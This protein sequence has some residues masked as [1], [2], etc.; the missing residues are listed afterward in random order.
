ML[1][2]SCRW[3]YYCLLALTL[4]EPTCCALLFTADAGR[5]TSL[6]L[7]NPLRRTM[8]T[9]QNV[10]H[11]TPNTPWQMVSDI[12]PRRAAKKQRAPT[13]HDLEGA[14][15]AE[16]EAA[17]QDE[18][19]PEEDVAEDEQQEEAEEEQQHEEEQEE[20]ARPARQQRASRTQQQRRQQPAGNRRPAAAKGK[21]MAAAPAAKGKAT[22]K[23]AAGRRRGQR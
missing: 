11:K 21:A 19:Q 8:P 1:G 4:L 20:E 2:G 10:V 5:L 6:P 3:C 15:A 7:P 18:E 9:V 16:A 14:L 17:E 23:A 12:R 22:K 13:P